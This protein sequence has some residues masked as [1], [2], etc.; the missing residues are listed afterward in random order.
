[1]ESANDV[2]LKLI[3]SN[4]QDGFHVLDPTASP[5]K[6][7]HTQTRAT[8]EG[9]IKDIDHKITELTAEKDKYL[10][11]LSKISDEKKV[12]ALRN[13]AS[14]VKRKSADKKGTQII[15]VIAAMKKG[16][17]ILK[18][19][20]WGAPHYHQFELTP[21]SMYLRWYSK[22]KK[23]QRYKTAIKIENIIHFQKG[24]LYKQEQADSRA[25]KRAFSISYT[26]VVN[27]EAKTLEVVAKT[28]TDYEIWTKGLEYCL[29]K[30]RKVKKQDITYDAKKHFPKETYMEIHK[31]DQRA[32]EHGLAKKEDPTPEA[33]AKSFKLLQDKFAAT[34]TLLSTV[35]KSRNSENYG[36]MDSIM[37]AAERIK[38]LK[39][40]MDAVGEH[41]KAKSKK[42][43]VLSYQTYDINVEVKALEEKLLVLQ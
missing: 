26:D 34:E 22:K 2:N 35:I 20:A 6:P 12:E 27:N 9:K 33:M 37:V 28:K 7:D 21:D 30:I 36:S 8:L 18:Y 1:M 19:G 10:T 11:E 41:L 13:N 43:S 14:V 32:Y 15:D 29:R 42:L 31:R 16:T 38:E 3:E 5:P 23:R 40:L 4:I 17:Q 24:H 39:V 25:H